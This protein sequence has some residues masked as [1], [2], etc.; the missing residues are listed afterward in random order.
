MKNG[1][2]EKRKSF[3]QSYGSEALDASNLMMPLVFFMA[4]NDPRM[5]Q[6]LDATC[7]DPSEG[8]SALGEPR[9]SLQQ[10]AIQRWAQR[11]GRNV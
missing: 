8:G 1:W 11:Q 4:P 6:T 10:P 2:S 9:L 3:V 7:K 5:L